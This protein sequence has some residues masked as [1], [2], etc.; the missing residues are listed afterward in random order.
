LNGIT[1][2]ALRRKFTRKKNADKPH[3][4]GFTNNPQKVTLIVHLYKITG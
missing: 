1:I 2:G 3:D 4:T